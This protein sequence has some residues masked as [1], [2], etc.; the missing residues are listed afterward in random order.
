MSL[1][2]Y[3]TLVPALVRDDSARVS[4]TDRDGAIASAVARYSDD[5]PRRRVDDVTASGANALPLPA[6]W[7]DGWSRIQGLEYPVGD[8]PPTMLDPERYTLY[9]GTDQAE[10]IMLYDAVN[11]GD[12]VRCVYTIRHTL[13]S[14]TDTVPDQDREAVA[15]WAAALLCDQLAA[16]HANAGDTTI[17]A[18]V[19]DRTSRARE[20]A[21]RAKVLR[22]R[23]FS[24]LGLD[25]K[26]NAP[27]GADVNQSLPDSWGADRLLH[28]ARLR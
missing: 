28:P 24:A 18:D 9:L 8:I 26:R 27:A 12:T 3:Q 25:E 10:T 5:R 16:L 23:Y 7:V 22:A 17:Q 11:T 4:D 21:N 2:D 6:Q 20:Y 19:V 14:S 13:N 15:C 1:A